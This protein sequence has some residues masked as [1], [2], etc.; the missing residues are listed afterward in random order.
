MET[1]LDCGGGC[2]PCYQGKACLSYTDCVSYVCSAGVCSTPTCTD[3]VKNQGETDKD[4]G[5]SACSKCA[6]GKTCA[7]NSDCTGGRCDQG[8]CSSCR[9]TIKNGDEVDIDCGGALCAACADGKV[10]R[11]R[12][13]L[14]EPEVSGRRLHLVRRQ[15]A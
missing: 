15:A 8:L 6:D 12:H 1:D 7:S 13:G 4:C 14:P 11:R 5:G 3:M 2:P 9:D 10:C